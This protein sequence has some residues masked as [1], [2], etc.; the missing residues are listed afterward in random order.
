VVVG[1]HFHILP[2]K[3]CR[4]KGKCRNRFL[5]TARRF[6][7][8]RC[9]S[10]SGGVARAGRSRR[11]WRKGLFCG[12]I[13]PKR[14]QYNTRKSAG[15]GLHRNS[16]PG[17]V[18]GLRACLKRLFRLCRDAPVGRLRRATGTSL[19]L[20]SSF[21]HTLLANL[22]AGGC[23]RV[24]RNRANYFRKRGTDICDA[25]QFRT[26]IRAPRSAGTKP[27]RRGTRTARR[28]LSR[29]GGECRWL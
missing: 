5:T 11:V 2:K 26:G 4:K 12:R 13:L 6:G 15:A 27:R 10:C 14:S 18:V 17:P 29:S 19:H 28:T 8:S 1:N 3:I 20:Q 25:S 24:S 9:G 16:V 23:L 7:K 21:S 22:T